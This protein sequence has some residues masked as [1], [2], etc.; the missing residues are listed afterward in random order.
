MAARRV[1]LVAVGGA[2][3]L[4]VGFSPLG[5]AQEGGVE[6]A[7][8]DFGGLYSSPSVEMGATSSGSSSG[9]S[10]G[11]SSSGSASG[12]SS[13]GSHRPSGPAVVPL[14]PTIMCDSAASDD[15]AL[16]LSTGP[17]SSWCFGPLDEGRCPSGEL[18]PGAAPPGAAAGPPDPEVLAQQA[19]QQLRL[20]LPVPQHSPDL[21]L[22]DGQA[23]TVVG[24]FTWFWTDP[25][26]WRTQRQRV[27]AGPVW[28]EVTATPVQLAMEPG[29][30]TAPIY[31]AGPGTPYDR[32]Y[33]LHSASPDCDVV[34]QRP[35]TG[36]VAAHWSITWE[37]TWHGWTGT[38]P[39]GGDLP[40]MTSRAQT[41]LVIAEAQ[42]LRTE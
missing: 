31:C 38:S 21:R 9:G 29:D 6:V 27:E 26:A 11:D 5:S 19:F 10:S 15:P 16:M 41:Q 39:T 32:S 33:G 35:S 20:P 42:A 2:A 4:C 37:V 1:P 23:A 12:G 36:P 22:Q 14:C 13:G 40:P 17:L 18:R 25:S 34:Y 8:G 28:A 24:E 7:P 30:G 3:L